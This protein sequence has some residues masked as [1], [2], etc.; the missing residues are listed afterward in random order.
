MHTF[1]STKAVAKRVI[2]NNHEK[3]TICVLGTSKKDTVSY[4]DLR[5]ETA[6]R[7]NT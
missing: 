2:C 4:T 3:G 1:L 6:G 7:N 5:C